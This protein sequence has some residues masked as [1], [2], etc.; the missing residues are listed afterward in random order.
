MPFPKMPGRGTARAVGKELSAFD[1]ERIGL[2]KEEFNA[3]T[4]A[5]AEALRTYTPPK[6]LNDTLSL[7]QTFKKGEVPPEHRELA[8]QDLSAT[9]DLHAAYKDTPAKDMQALYTKYLPIEGES[10]NLSQQAKIEEHLGKAAAGTAVLGLGSQAKA[11]IPGANPDANTSRRQLLTD[12]LRNTGTAIKDTGKVAAGLPEAAL[13]MATGLAD[14]AGTGLGVGAGMLASKLRGEPVDLNAAADI[15]REGQ[16]TTWQPKTGAGQRAAESVGAAFKPVG[17]AMNWAGEQSAEKTGS[18]LVGAGILA[19]LNVVDPAMLEANTARL[20]AL[21]G[22]RE[23]TPKGP[24][25]RSAVHEAI[26]KL[27]PKGTIHQYIQTLRNMPGIKGEELAD[28]GADSLVD[29]PVTREQFA[30]LLR[31]RSPQFE[32]KRQG[33][34]PLDMDTRRR[35]LALLDEALS[36]PE[37]YAELTKHSPRSNYNLPKWGGTRNLAGHP[38]DLATWQQ[39]ARHDF[40][41]RDFLEQKAISEQIDVPGY[42]VRM[43]NALPPASYGDMRYLLDGEANTDL[44]NYQELLQTAK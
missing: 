21:K 44:S 43:K 7:L 24:V 41:L 22:V 38:T 42:D 18:P 37:K 17:E 15:A 30:T 32:L 34:D 20:A 5:R 8:W 26:P 14:Q 31:N 39:E 4:A 36:S 6:A 2:L 3:E 10:A 33:T 35:T 19:G 1:K 12:I 13:T 23:S 29:G 40:N 25:F 11:G 9:N 16:G 27:Q 28:M